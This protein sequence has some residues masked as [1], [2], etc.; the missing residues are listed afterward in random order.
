MKNTITERTF[1]GLINKLD[2]TRER[3]SEPEDRSIKN[4]QIEVQGGKN[5]EK[6]RGEKTFQSIQGLWD[7][8]EW[9]NIG[10]SGI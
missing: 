8:T 2:T 9:Y 1:D 3:L 4:I 10:V 6:G 7:K 5:N